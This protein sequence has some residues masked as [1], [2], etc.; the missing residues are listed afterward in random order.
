MTADIAT[1]PVTSP[2]TSRSVAWGV[3]RL[4]ARRHVRNPVLWL[5]VAA[6]LY[7]AWRSRSIDWNAGPYQ[8]L[9]VD[10]VPAAWAV[11]VLGVISGGRDHLP[12]LRPSPTISVATGHDRIAAGRLLGL[13]V[14]VAVVAAS[15][16][17]VVVSAR[18]SGGYTIGELSRRTDDANHT[19]PEIAQPILLAA[20]CAAAGVAVGRAVR[21]TAVAL[22]GGTVLFLTFGLISWA[23][24]W[25]PAV[26]VAPVQV[27]PFSVEIPQGDPALAPAGWWLSS[28]GQYQDG[29]RRLVVDPVVAAGHDVVLLG[30][31]A[32]FV[33]WALRRRVG[34]ILAGVGS[35]L[36]VVGVAIQVVAAPW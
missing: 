28:P 32:L 2:P 21:Q 33:G 4:E 1:V 16:G 30:A 24:Q 36:V 9:P 3:A 12:G 17:L 14:P 29:W 19:L 26:Y 13:L 8:A 18:L 6:S 20:M 22:V 7:M 25:S 31:T 27:Q 11:Y 10:P 15:V 23:W 5:G 35:A 34:L